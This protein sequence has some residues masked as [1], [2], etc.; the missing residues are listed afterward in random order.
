MIRVAHLTYTVQTISFLLN[1]CLTFGSLGFGYVIGRGCL[2]D[3]PL[4]ITLYTK[5]PMCVPDRHRLAHVVIAC[6]WKNR[7]VLCE[8]TEGRRVGGTLGNS[9]LLSSELCPRCLFPLLQIFLINHPTSGWFLRPPT[10]HFY[11]II[12]KYVAKQKKKKRE[13]KIKGDILRVGREAAHPIPSF[14][15]S[16]QVQSLSLNSYF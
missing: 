7:C 8:S 16:T 13:V 14:L 2:Y 12:T 5:S 3:P 15:Y 10:N 4:V 11:E 1:T 9:C 6:G